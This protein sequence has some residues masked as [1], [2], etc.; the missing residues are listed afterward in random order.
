[1]QEINKAQS[2]SWNSGLVARSPGESLVSEGPLGRGGRVTTPFSVLLLLHK[3]ALQ[4]FFGKERSK[5]DSFQFLK[6]GSVLGMAQQMW[7]INSKGQEVAMQNWRGEVVMTCCFQNTQL[8][9][10]F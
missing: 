3:T 8:Y 1:M 9:S 7:Y 2:P 5:K 6:F 10:I 4:R